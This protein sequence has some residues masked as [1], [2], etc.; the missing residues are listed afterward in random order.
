MCD[1]WEC[2]GR[3]DLEDSA[4]PLLLLSMVFR[5]AKGAVGEVSKQSAWAPGGMR[6]VDHPEP[7]PQIFP[8]RAFLP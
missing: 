3:S 8:C 1:G 5:R 6:Y 7:V 4:L 2:M